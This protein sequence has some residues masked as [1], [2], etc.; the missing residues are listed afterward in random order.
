MSQIT[1]IPIYGDSKLEPVAKG[2]LANGDAAFINADGNYYV[3]KSAVEINRLQKTDRTYT[4]P[5]KGLC[6]YWDLI[7]EAGETLITDFSWVYEQP[8]ADWG[9]IAGRFGFYTY[10]NENYQVIESE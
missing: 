4:C 6:Y 9:Q 3:D 5:Y 8:N 10:D 1:I 2:K 7:D